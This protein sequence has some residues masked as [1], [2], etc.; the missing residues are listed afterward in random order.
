MRY[1]TVKGY[2]VDLIEYLKEPHSIEVP[3]TL[4]FYLN[5]NLT[6]IIRHYPF[7][8]QRTKIG[9]AFLCSK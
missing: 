9:V 5:I 3:H 4:C 6:G 1:M 7:V 8:W 2:P